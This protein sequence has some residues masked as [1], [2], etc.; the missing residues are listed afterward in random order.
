MLYPHLSM[1]VFLVVNM[2]N[3]A[4]TIKVNKIWFNYHETLYGAKYWIKGTIKV[5]RRLKSSC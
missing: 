5:N 4:N 2:V 1:L 3:V